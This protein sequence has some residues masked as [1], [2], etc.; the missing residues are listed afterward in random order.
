MHGVEQPHGESEH[1]C[2]G[3]GV[4]RVDRR[5]T[6]A[7]GPGKPGMGS[8]RRVVRGNAIGV[9]SDDRGDLERERLRVRLRPERRAPARVLDR[10]REWQ[11]PVR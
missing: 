1:V 11:S 2:L 10:Q 7:R 4:E 3:G 6:A 5:E 8:H 9:G